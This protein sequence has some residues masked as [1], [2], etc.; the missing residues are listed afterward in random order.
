MKKPWS[1]KK[2]SWSSHSYHIGSW[3]YLNTKGTSGWPLLYINGCVSW[4]STGH[5]NGFPKITETL[6]SWARRI[7]MGQL[8]I[9]LNPTIIDT[10]QIAKVILKR[11]TSLCFPQPM[12]SLPATRN[13]QCDDSL[14]TE[15]GKGIMFIMWFPCTVWSLYCTCIVVSEYCSVTFLN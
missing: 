12:H 14:Q 13:V 1:L 3:I 11:P 9:W 15:N 7:S 10:E 2:N 8:Y 4:G 6:S 5:V